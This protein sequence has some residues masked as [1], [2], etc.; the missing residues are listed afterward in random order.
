MKNK[1]NNKKI[2]KQSELIVI[3]AIIGAFASRYVDISYSYDKVWA[4]ILLLI[5][6]ALILLIVSFFTLKYIYRISN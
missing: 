1:M 2:L 6:G 3:A 5:L 4:Q